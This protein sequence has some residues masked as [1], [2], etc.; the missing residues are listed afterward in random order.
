MKN[1][2]LAFSLLLIGFS[3]TFSQSDYQE[4][5]IESGWKSIKPLITDK[6]FVNKLLGTPKIDENNYHNYLTEEAFVQVN[7]SSTPC[8]NNQ[9]GRGKFNV[10]QDRVLDYTVRLKKPIKLDEF[11]FEREKYIKDTS[12]DLVNTVSYH[13]LKFEGRRSS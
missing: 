6:A 8:K 10:L 12:G 11:N 5:M 7:Y 2:I 13:N 1:L 4:L 3:Y 9:Y